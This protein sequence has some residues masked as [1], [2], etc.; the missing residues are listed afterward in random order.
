MAN[1]RLEGGEELEKR[2]AMALHL[3]YSRMVEVR[4][5]RGGREDWREEVER[6]NKVIN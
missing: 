3:H 4:L 5:E 1:I 6:S 2:S